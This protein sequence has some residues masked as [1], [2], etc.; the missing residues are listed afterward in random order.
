MLELIYCLEV[1][2]KLVNKSST[3]ETDNN[4]VDDDSDVLSHGFTLWYLIYFS[5][6]LP[7][8][9]VNYNVSS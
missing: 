5:S 1:R 3:E 8:C 4:D 2:L 6:Q 7:S 9:D